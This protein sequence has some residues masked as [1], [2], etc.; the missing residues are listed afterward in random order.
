MKFAY[1]VN[2]DD[3]S[4]GTTTTTRHLSEEEIRKKKYMKQILEDI[5]SNNDNAIINP[6][7]YP[8]VDKK[9]KKLLEH[10]P[11]GF[12]SDSAFLE[13]QNLISSI[14]DEEVKKYDCNKEKNKKNA[15][16][17]STVSEE[18]KEEEKKKDPCYGIVGQDTPIGEHQN[19]KKM[20]QKRSRNLDPKYKE[21]MK[22]IKEQEEKEQ[23]E[24]ERRRKEPIKFKLPKRK[25]KRL[26]QGH[27]FRLILLQSHLR[28]VVEKRHV[29]EGRRNLKEKRRVEEGRRRKQKRN[30][31]YLENINENQ[32]KLIK[33]FITI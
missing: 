4:E 22:A 6:Y 28:K 18:K 31:K 11:S 24:R 25:K 7:A 32:N 26:L 12:R 20:E 3:Q 29:E 23:E 9:I 10:G 8:N 1:K 16:T 19:W 5:I 30:E 33:L 14:I 21:I 2:P 17:S 15:T 13:V 27:L